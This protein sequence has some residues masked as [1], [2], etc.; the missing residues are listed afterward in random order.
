MDSEMQPESCVG[1]ARKSCTS[2]V[3]GI[4]S[5]PIQRHV[6]KTR[7]RPILGT[8]KMCANDVVSSVTCNP[9]TSTFARGLEADMLVTMETQ[10]FAL[11]VRELRL[12]CRSKKSPWNIVLFANWNVNICNGIISTL[13]CYLA[14]SR[15]TH[16]KHH[17]TEYICT[18]PAVTSM[19]IR[20]SYGCDRDYHVSIF[21]DVIIRYR[22]KMAC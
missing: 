8:L 20:V 13:S 9:V 16:I 1:Q 12:S 15:H 4:I 14:S 19:S 11:W 7:N 18:C 5:A 17:W 2:L 21:Y 3:P 22:H 6:V 10:S